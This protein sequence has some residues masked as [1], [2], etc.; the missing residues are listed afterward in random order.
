[1][2]GRNGD[3]P[4]DTPESSQLG[5]AFSSWE[6]MARA[7]RGLAAGLYQRIPQIEDAATR[8]EAAAEVSK[9]AAVRA[10]AAARASE[11][12]ARVGAEECR[13]LKE[14]VH[15]L[16]MRI[17]GAEQQADDA[18]TAASEARKTGHEL[19]RFM[20]ETGRILAERE[21]DPNDKAMTSDRVRAIADQA[22][23][24]AVRDAKVEK[25]DRLEQARKD[26]RERVVKI[27]WKTVG[28]ALIA[29]GGAVGLSL[30]GQCQKAAGRLEVMQQ[31]ARTGPATSSPPV[32][33]IPFPQEP[34]TT[35]AVPS[36]M[37]EAGRRRP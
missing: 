6:E 32:V 28:A 5:P 2:P 8:I 37:P 29:I 1:M 33:P 4:S 31:V 36:A 17:G 19:E 12:A 26:R 14:A 24:D 35:P 16:T 23:A 3:H 11:A 30:Y 22:R 25:Y 21:K 9:D 18:R 7:Y 34:A 27:L 15:V 20:A 13:S 10:E